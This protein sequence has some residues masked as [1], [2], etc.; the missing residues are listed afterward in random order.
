ME[1]PGRRA[2]TFW[3]LLR[4]MRD[5][6]G[7]TEAGRRRYGNLYSV[8]DF[9]FTWVLL[10]TDPEDVKAILTDTER[11]RGGDVPRRLIS[12]LAGETSVLTTSGPTHMR[13]RKLLLP[14]LHQE[15]VE[16]WS[17]RI[18][19]IAE[20]ELNALPVGKPVAMLAPMQRITLDVIC[21]LIFGAEDD[22]EIERLRNA[23][24]ELMDP[25]VAPL[26]F[27]PGVLRWE[28]RLN[29]ANVFFR[30][31]GRLDRLIFGM[32]DRRRR[33]GDGGGR[34]DALSM[35]LGARD[36]EGEPLTDTELRDQLVTLLAAGHETTATGLA[37]AIERL[38]RNEGARLRAIAETVDGD[39]TD[40]IDAVA[41]ETLRLRPPIVNVP[42]VA[43]RDTELGGHR[44]RAGTTVA[45]MVSLTHRRPDLW[46]EPLAFKPERFLDG[47]PLP[48]AY[49]PFGGG[50]RRCIGASLA[51]LEMRIVLQAL[52]RRLEPL[53]APA[54]E[55]RVG[56]TGVVLRPKRGGRVVLRRLAA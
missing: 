2:P 20:A 41:K 5:P 27:L 34:D 40:Y 56:L 26:F 45:A 17:G 37:W 15:L 22:A 51:A 53:P 11:F 38:S 42:R 4:F 29:P 18:E 21:R 36:E 46:P 12:P 30:R 14:V 19:K 50:I 7:Y 43:T 24:L 8:R 55:E 25:R 23:L 31:R 52:L 6:L 49:A 16:R 54:P 9:L 3:Q 48:Y 47:K 32:V 44:I 13:Q 10:A 39:G 33:E 35:L 1:V 28:S